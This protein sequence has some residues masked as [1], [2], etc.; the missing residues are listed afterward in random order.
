MS[1]QKATAHL[2]KLG[3]QDHILTF[4]TSTAT[5]ALAAEA[6]GTQPER[7]AKSLTFIVDDSPVMVVT[8]GDA[9]I[10]NPK[11]KAQ[12]GVK[13]KMIPG[14]NVEAY[15]GHDIGGVC[16]FGINEGV[17]VYLDASLR[18]FDTVYPAA[19][20]AGSAVRLSIEELERASGSPEWID[21][22]KLPE[23]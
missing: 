5:V 4:N 22:T 23:I 11:F 14:E 8:A 3:L 1:L 6:V 12:F 10:S 13:A 2:T 7:I 9:K 21:V 18:R 15:I 17:A 16:P 20:D 19:G